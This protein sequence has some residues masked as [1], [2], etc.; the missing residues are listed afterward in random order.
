MADIIRIEEKS[1]A[2]EQFEVRV[3]FNDRQFS[4][5]VKNPHNP[6]TQKKLD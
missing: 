6:E 5:T 3:I 2:G 1:F 4:V